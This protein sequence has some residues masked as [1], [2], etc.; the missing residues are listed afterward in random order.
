MPASLASKA[1]NEGS[2]ARKRQEFEAM[3][4]ERLKALNPHLE[5]LKRMRALLPPDS[6]DLLAIDVLYFLVEMTP[7][8]QAKSAARR[9]QWEIHG[10][11][12]VL[13][14]MKLVGAA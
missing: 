14:R 10:K 8:E 11:P 4:A 7:I 3:K 6:P 9:A 5:L 13:A 12:L 1:L 2:I